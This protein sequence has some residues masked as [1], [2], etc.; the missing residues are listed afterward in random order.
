LPAAPPQAELLLLLV[1]VALTAS[2]CNRGAANEPNGDGKAPAAMDAGAQRVTAREEALRAARVWRAP[3]IPISQVDFSQNPQTPHGFRSSE[4]VSCRFVIQK[5]GGT[6]PKFR[7]ELPDGRIVKVKYGSG[8][9][10]PPAETAATRLLSALGFGADEMFVVRRVRCA[11]CPP[12]PFRALRCA[13]A[14]GTPSICFAGGMDYARVRTF[15]WAVIEHPI[16][17]EVIEA[18]EDQGWAWFELDKID[19]AH[20]GSPR[21]EVDALRLLAVVLAHWDNKS[22]NQRLICLPGG[23]EANGGCRTPLAMVQDL[24]ATFGPLKLDLHN[25]RETP[26][27]SDRATCTVSMQTLPFHGATFPDHRITEDGRQM[28]LGL[29]QQLSDAQLADLFT[30][31]RVVAYDQV[32]AEARDA[33]VWVTVFRD[34]LRQIGDGP[35]CPQ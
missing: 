25:W 12:F 7:C 33:A 34:K 29:V 20:G 21:A 13:A 17:A 5:V 18:T 35:R 30:T 27:W 14:I 23:G 4:E 9:P 10:E 2:A 24:G 8:N 22:A 16:E 32:L 26:V 3:S 6:T 1:A 19:P 15:E 11:G 28:L 31:S